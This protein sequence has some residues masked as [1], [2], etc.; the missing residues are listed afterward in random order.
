MSDMDDDARPETPGQ[1][2]SAPGP[3]TM[4]LKAA[5]VPDGQDP[6]PDLALGRYP[7]RLRARLD[8]RTGEM[9]TQAAGG[10]FIQDVPAEWKPDPRED[11][12]DGGAADP[13]SGMDGPFTEAGP[14][15]EE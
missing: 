12:D 11:G 10:L 5:F 7:L 2:R 1:G 13:D 6:P 14:F 3:M 15:T 8:P 4:V 9:I